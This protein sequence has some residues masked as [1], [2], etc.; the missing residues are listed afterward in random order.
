MLP[1][2]PHH[3]LLRSD[4]CGY[5]RERNSMT[6]KIVTE[7][8]SLPFG[9][10]HPYKL[11]GVAPYRFVYQIGEFMV[12]L[13]VN[14][15]IVPGLAKSWIIS[16]DRKSIR[17]DIRSEIYN[18]EEVKQSFQRIMKFGQ[19]SHSNFDIQI[20]HI[21]VIDNNTIIFHTHGDAASLLNP[22]VMSDATILP[23]NHWTHDD[24]GHEVPDWTKSRGPYVFD[25]GKF[26]LQPGSEIIFKPNPKHYLYHKDQLRWRILQLQPDA[27][28]D[29]TELSK[30]LNN[31]PSYTTRMASNWY[32]L[33]RSPANDIEFY[34]TKENALGFILPNKRG[35]F[36]DRKLRLSLMKR[37][38]ETQ[39]HFTVPEVK[40]GVEAI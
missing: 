11:V 23:D 26:P 21:E 31:S 12:R 13:D 22:M 1:D 18:A 40:R 19:T 14:N 27:P 24:S 5:C 33:F 4:E 20:E 7:L 29:L 37:V 9:L 36:S 16:N 34:K 3:A 8:N 39:A 15:Q 25:S 17:F 32:S 38:F 2:I 30:L 10:P 35:K 28:K 6:S